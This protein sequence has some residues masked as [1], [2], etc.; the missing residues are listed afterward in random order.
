MMNPLVKTRYDDKLAIVFYDGVCG[1]CSRI[2]DII[3]SSDK[4]HRLLF[5]PLQGETSLSYGIHNGDVE[6]E[7][8]KVLVKGVLYEKSD[9]VLIICKVL[10]MPYVLLCIFVLLPRNFRDALY[11][12]IA[13]RRYSWFGK[14]E[15]CRLPTPE[16][17]SYFLP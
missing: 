16:E 7:T 5:A 4:K 12:Y 3:L 9:A 11:S 1:L 2:V 6:P 8:I 10:G 14:K 17:R 13:A 15:S